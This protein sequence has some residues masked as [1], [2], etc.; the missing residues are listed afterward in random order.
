MV[1]L[2]LVSGVSQRRISR[3][4]GA[5]YKTVVRKLLFLADQAR[6]T[7][8]EYLEYIRNS[9][10]PIERIVF[11]EMESFERSK[12]LPLSIPLV[13]EADSRRIL[14]FRVTQMPAKGPLA[15]ISVKKYGFREDLRPQAANELFSEIR[16]AISRKAEIAT[17]QNP[18]YPSWLK[19][20]FTEAKHISFKGRR[21]CAVGQGELK[22]IGFDPL[23]AL[24]HTCAML[25]ANVN[26]LFRKTWNTTKR[27]DRLAAHIELYALFHN[28]VL[29]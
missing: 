7:R 17:D 26:R 1:F 27:P 12:C 28:T 2:L 22:K 8:L 5:N 13:V 9:G 14:S 21:G 16:D 19:P 10:T 18:K 29:I 4:F 6:M 25:R 11:D 23:F 20:H 15:A 3:S 24:N